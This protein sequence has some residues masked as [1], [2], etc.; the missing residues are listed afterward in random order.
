MQAYVP[1][2]QSVGMVCRFLC[3]QRKFKI[4][5]SAAFGKI[6]DAY[7]KAIHKYAEKHEIP[8]HHVLRQRASDLGE[9][10]K[11]DELGRA[12]PFLAAKRDG[13]V[14][15]NHS[16]RNTARDLYAASVCICLRFHRRNQ[17]GA[18]NSREG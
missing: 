16:R 5:S 3:W 13:P 9:V 10:Y 12:F 2:L 18:G 1:K 8:V 11:N 17:S 6:G 14:G 7:V 15:M 4:P